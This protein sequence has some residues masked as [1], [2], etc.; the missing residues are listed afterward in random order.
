MPDKTGTKS[1]YQRTAPTRDQYIESLA[2]QVERMREALE[3]II[4]E[5]EWTDINS[6]NLDA[7]IREVRAALAA[8]AEP[9][10]TK[11]CSLCEGRG[12]RLVRWPP[13]SPAVMKECCDCR[14]SGRLNM[15]GI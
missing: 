10:K 5:W 15:D 6:G 9:S 11:L 8:K 3:K 13:D 12:K 2:S 7:V 14:G 4:Q 1:P